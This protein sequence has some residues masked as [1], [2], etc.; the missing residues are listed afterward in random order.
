MT[1]FGAGDAFADGMVDM[2]RAE[3]EGVDAG[4][5]RDAQSASPTTFRACG[6]TVLKPIV[7]A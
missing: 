4:V 7:K 5:P 3:D 1:G 6:E 2:M